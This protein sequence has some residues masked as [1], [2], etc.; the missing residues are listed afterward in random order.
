MTENIKKAK[1]AIRD[2]QVREAM[3]EEAKKPKAKEDTDVVGV[4]NE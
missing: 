1:Q 3:A 2:Q 4:P